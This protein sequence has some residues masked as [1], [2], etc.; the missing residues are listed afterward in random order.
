MTTVVVE[1]MATT[2]AVLVVIHRQQLD[3][4]CTD[5]SSTSVHYTNEFSRLRL[6]KGVGWEVVG[7]PRPGV[8]ATGHVYD[9]IGHRTR[10]L[11]YGVG[12]LICDVRPNTNRE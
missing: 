4:V 9:D 10:C 12:P 3:L 2:G 5:Y 8:T 11:V 6:F 7:S 1:W